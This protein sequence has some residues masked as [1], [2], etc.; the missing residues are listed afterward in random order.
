M[1]EANWEKKTVVD[2]D[3]GERYTGAKQL[4]SGNMQTTIDGRTYQ[5]VE[6]DW[7]IDDEPIGENEF[8]EKYDV[9][10]KGK[11]EPISSEI[12]VAELQRRV[13][14]SVDNSDDPRDILLSVQGELGG[15]SDT[16][17]YYERGDMT[18]DTELDEDDI[19]GTE[20]ARVLVT[21]VKYGSEMGVDVERVVNKVLNGV[22]DD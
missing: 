8:D 5:I 17:V 16:H 11:D 1:T 22:E 13:H 6:G 4:V 15:L 20:L 14:Q 19:V 18:G 9:Q 12:T 3:T 2:N 10:R 21:L 7:I